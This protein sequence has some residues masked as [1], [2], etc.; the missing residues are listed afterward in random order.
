MDPVAAVS[1][2]IPSFWFGSRVQLE[3]RAKTITTMH[4]IEIPKFVMYFL[5]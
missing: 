3:P 5:S 1:S 2:M 4:V